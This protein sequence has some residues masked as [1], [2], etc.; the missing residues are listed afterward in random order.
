MTKERKEDNALE[1]LKK[2]YEKIQK[3]H[4]LPSFKEMNEDFHIE[5]LSDV[6]TE[7]LIREVR[8]M[9]A[10]KLANY[11]RFVESLLNPVNAPMFV[12]SI[13]KLIEPEQK[14]RLSEIYRELM[15]RE[16]EFIA[17]DLEF[18]EER[19]AKFIKESF[20][21]WQ[22]VKK[23]MSGILKTINDKW[24]DKAETNNKGYFG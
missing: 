3:K 7:I 4:E 15:K 18:N 23:D 24:D 22:D 17:I 1:K 9:V 10:D 12:F 20:K 19:E 8:R 5:K 2:E 21:F 16:M 11:M 6:E 14:K 13:V